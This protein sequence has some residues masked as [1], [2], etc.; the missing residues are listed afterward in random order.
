M[1]QFFGKYRGKVVNNVDPEQRGRI[2]VNVPSVLG[3]TLSNWAEPCMPV[4]GMQMGMY[5][6]PIVGATVWVEFE[7]GDPDRPIWVGGFW[8]LGA[9]VPPLA[10]AGM[11][12]SPNMVMQTSGQNTLVISDLPGPAGGI[13]LKS[14]T[15]ASISISDTGITIS[16]GQGAVITLQGPTVN[17]NAGALVIT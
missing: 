4:A 15:G 8:G 12:A 5:V 11:P 10:L 17:I 9:E 14:K 13:L 1:K 6:V 3:P 2:Q 16:N 7:E